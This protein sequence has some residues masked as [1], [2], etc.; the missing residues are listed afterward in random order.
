MLTLQRCIADVPGVSRWMR[1]P[2]ESTAEAAEAAKRHVGLMDADN[3]NF[4]DEFVVK[5]AWKP[6]S[7]AT[8]QP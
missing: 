5:T 2:V 3:I 6:V 4:E 7:L 8:D 1:S